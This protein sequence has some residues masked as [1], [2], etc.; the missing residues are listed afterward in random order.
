MKIGIDA[1]LY[2]T[3]NAGLGRYVKELVD[4][5]IKLKDNDEYALFL[6]QENWELVDISDNS[7]VKKVLADFRWYS[8]WEQ[9]KF[10]A[11]IKAEKI[12][13]MHFPHFNAP[14]FYRGKFIVTIHDLILDALPRLRI[15]ATTLGRFKYYLKFI[16][17]RLVIK[18]ALKKSAK[19]IAL[20]EYGRGDLI[21]YY[22]VKPEKIQVI[23]NGAARPLDV[24]KSA[25][26]SDDSKIILRYNIGKP[27]ILYVGNA[28][29][30]KNLDQI[31][32]AFRKI[33][34]RKDVFLVLSGKMDYFYERLKAKAREL[35]LADE[36]IIFTDYVSDEV[37]AAL[38]RNASCFV[39]P[40]LYEGFGLPPLEAMSY[41]VP[42][43][44]S[45]SSCLPEILGPAAS[46]FDP[47]S[48][49]DLANKVLSI[50][51]DEKSREQLVSAGFERVKRYDWNKSV[52]EVV[53]LYHNN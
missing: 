50:L 9:I 37:L 52:R 18:N 35:G 43:V 47:L 7:R 17:Y 41:G 28:Y 39:F 36:K 15:R 22:Q 6:T 19:I 46:Y 25:E 49:D 16:G 42:V 10:P 51:D 29:P 53:S 33:K 45:S 14:V 23:Y 40:S 11:L 13:L 4:R 3:K 44:I 34:A 48:A 31:L 26:K 32:S 8:L 27:Y 21:K 38:Y 5:V 20:S 30:H 1:R 2:G 12:D 24:D